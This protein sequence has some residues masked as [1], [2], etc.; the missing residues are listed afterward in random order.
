VTIDIWISGYLLFG[1]KE[2][3]QRKTWLKEQNPPQASNP[4]LPLKTDFS[5]PDPS[6]GW[7]PRFFSKKKVG[8]CLLSFFL[9]R[10]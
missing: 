2:T 3:N 5:L 8:L 1:E 10:K 4:L 6:F 7:V 9:K